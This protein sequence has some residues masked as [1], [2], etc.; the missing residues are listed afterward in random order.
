VAGLALLFTAF[1]GYAGYFGPLKGLSVL[2]IRLMYW[3][4]PKGEIVFYGASNFTFWR[5][6]GEDLAPLAVQN[7]GFGGSKDRDLMER[8]KSLLYPYEPRVLAV[9]SGSNDFA[10]MTAE[11]IC[12]NKDKMYTM[13]RKRMPDTAFVVMSMLPL[14]GREENWPESMKIN[15]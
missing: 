2:R 12:V 1:V 4:R 6:M 3:R 9:Q 5:K 14:P 8:A 11:D 15:A 10:H 7:H 13:F